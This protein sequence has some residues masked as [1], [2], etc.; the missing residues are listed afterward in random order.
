MASGS[1]N[2]VI[3]IGRL[4]KDPEVKY[5]PSGAPVAKF[6]LARMKSSRTAVASSRSALNGITSSLGT[7]W[8]RS[9]GSTLPKASRCTSREASAAGNGKTRQETSAQ[10]MTSWR[11]T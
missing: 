8:P 10:A 3:L 6:T 7:S 1:V 9:A 2:K 11:V 5:T 4:G